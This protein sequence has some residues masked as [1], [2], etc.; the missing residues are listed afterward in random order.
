MA[1]SVAEFLA[2][3][4]MKLQYSPVWWPIFLLF[5]SCLTTAACLS[6]RA[7]RN[8]K[9][10]SLAIVVDPTTDVSSSHGTDK[11]PFLD[12]TRM[13]VHDRIVSK[14]RPGDDLSCVGVTANSSHFSDV[15]VL[16][17]PSARTTGEQGKFLEFRKQA[18]KGV[19]N[20]FVALRDAPPCKDPTKLCSD[21]Y[22]S[23]LL[24]ASSLR[25]S[26][27]KQ[28][29]M[30]AFSDFQENIRGPSSISEGSF[31]GID[32]V[33]LFAFP[34]SRK[35]HDYEP[36]RQALIKTLRKGNPRSIRVLFP[37]ESPT[38]N[39]EEALREL[40]RSANV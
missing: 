24:A 39:L 13:L 4:L 9:P 5:L 30:I 11:V 14:L 17:F 29:L 15:I 20:W 6:T 16:Q 37:A 18:E 2:G 8:E 22:G 27:E 31:E 21:I 28:K 23:M 33:A 10:I 32:I 1:I 25:R 19:E 35:P 38:F 40:R 34:K 36:F 7:G 3:G 26:A 12:Q